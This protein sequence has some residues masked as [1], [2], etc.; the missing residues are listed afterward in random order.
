MFYSFNIWCWCWKI[1]FHWHITLSGT[2]HMTKGVTAVRQKSQHLIWH[3]MYLVGIESLSVRDVYLYQYVYG[4]VS[5]SNHI[6]SLFTLKKSSLTFSLFIYIFL[7][8][9]FYVISWTICH[10]L[11]YTVSYSI[12]FLRLGSSRV[13]PYRR[14]S[15]QAKFKVDIFSWSGFELKISG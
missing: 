8:H 12:F 14:Q 1:Q 4:F 2:D 11:R 7:D 3:Y 6:L 9:F 5:Y 10:L 15:Y 13:G